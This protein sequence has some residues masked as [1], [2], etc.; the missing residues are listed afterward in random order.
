MPCKPLSHCSKGHKFDKANTYL[1]KTASGRTV[2]NCRKCSKDR[3][4]ATAAAV[5]PPG[6]NGRQ[7]NRDDD[8]TDAQFA[9][10]F[11]PQYGPGIAAVIL[12]WL[13]QPELPKPELVADEDGIVW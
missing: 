11:R 10:T 2:R 8:L 4:R 7:W 12:R 3:Q 5:A 13:Q 1:Y 9:D 6:S